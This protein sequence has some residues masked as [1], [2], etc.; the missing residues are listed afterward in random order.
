MVTLLSLLSSLY[1]HYIFIILE[2][3]NLLCS[4]LYRRFNI[5]T[6]STTFILTRTRKH[7]SLW[8]HSGRLVYINPLNLYFPDFDRII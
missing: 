5:A 6:S 3:R 2:R 8:Y 1:P 4:R 7:T